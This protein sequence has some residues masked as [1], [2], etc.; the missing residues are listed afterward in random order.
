MDSQAKGLNVVLR[1][2]RDLKNAG[3][4]DRELGQCIEEGRE[5]AAS[6]EVRVVV[7]IECV[8]MLREARELIE[9]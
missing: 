8:D 4:C 1:R 7:L 3:M 5:L 2:E 9:T 6:A